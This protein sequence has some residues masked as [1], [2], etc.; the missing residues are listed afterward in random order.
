MAAFFPEVLDAFITP[1]FLERVRGK[2]HYEEGQAAELRAVADKMLP[3][4]REEAFWE[5]RKSSVQDRCRTEDFDAVY[6]SV[7]MSLGS[8]VDRL[9]DEYAEKGLLSESYMIEALASELLLQGYDA[10]NRYIRSNTERH[11]ARYHFLGSE[12]ALPLELLPELLGEI[13][14][15][16]TCNEAFC[17][18]PQK[19][20]VFISE[21]TRDETVR[22][23]SVC[24]GCDQ[25][26]CPNR[27]EDHF[28]QE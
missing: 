6:E 16:I 3:L 28:A 5:R 12:A 20:V 23:K 2:F 15:R 26:R 11:V 24:V 9:Q 8:G 25:M 19:S 21:L 10:Y 13:T 1:S 27:I 18:L 4:M 14:S 17:M 22:C 7:V